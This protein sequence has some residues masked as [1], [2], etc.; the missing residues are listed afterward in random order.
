MHDLAGI[1][2]YRVVSTLPVCRLVV[3]VIRRIN[4]RYGLSLTLPYGEIIA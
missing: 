2:D 1:T 3:S 4:P